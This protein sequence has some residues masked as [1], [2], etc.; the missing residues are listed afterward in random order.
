MF[1][2]SGGSLRP[3]IDSASEAVIGPRD[4]VT[5]KP[6]SDQTNHTTRPRTATR[7][8]HLNLD[9]FPR[10]ITDQHSLAGADHQRAHEK[11]R[12]GPGPAHCLFMPLVPIRRTGQE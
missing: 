3:V 2:A 1:C 7:T 6:K 10:C 9:G 5:W 4:S 12:R 11:D 8:N